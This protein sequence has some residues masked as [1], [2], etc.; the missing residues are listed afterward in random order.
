MTP[1][2]ET[3]HPHDIEI[4]IPDRLPGAEL[5]RLSAIDGGMAAL[6][7]ASE[8]AMIAAAVA[9]GTMFP[10]PAVI[11]IAIA[12]VGARQQA[13]TVIAHDASH[14]R[15]FPDR[16]ANDLFG[17]LFLAWPM[18]ISV[19]GFRHF[20]SRHHRHLNT[21]KDGNRELWHTHGAEGELSPEW[22]FP[23]TAAGLVWLLARRAAFVT[24]LFWILRGLMGGFVM[25]APIWSKI[26]R[27]GLY[28]SSAFI[29]TRF[30]LWPMFLLF[31][32]VPYC[33]WHLMIQYTRLICEHSAVRSGDP[34]YAETRTTIPGFL[35]RI[36]V[37]P[38]NIGYHIEHHWYP[39]VPFYRL[40]DLH[41][42]L[43]AN[44]SYRANANVHRSIVS[45]LR[46]CV[47]GR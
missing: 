24:G 18:F 28:A 32:I 11:A 2:I 25:G 20:H 21:E 15:L 9:V 42:A 26:A 39:S 14:F 4:Q 38:R 12:F 22:R 19:E 6:C 43:M 23:K 13:L 40:P 45:S 47:S 33:T 36:F 10:S 30:E 46:E 37:L 7:I 31:W 16:L 35:G 8:W 3:A 5:R 17:N 29:L 44:P 27:G 1:T 41:R 34:R